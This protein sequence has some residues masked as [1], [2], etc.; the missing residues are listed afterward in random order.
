MDRHEPAVTE[1]RSTTPSTT[2]PRSRS[3]VAGNW[4]F[5][6]VLLLM[7]ISAPVAWISPRSLV[8]VE[9]PGLVD[10]SWHLD[11][12]FK[13]SRGIWIGRD[14]AFTHGPLFQWLSSLPARSTAIS[15]GGIYATWDTLPLWCAVL[16]GFL[17]LRLL[18]PQ[19]PA[20]KRFVLLLILCM[21]W[22]PSLRTMF[23]VFVFAALLR[24]WYAVAEE[25]VED[26]IFGCLA[27]VLSATAFLIAADQGMYALAALLIA[28]VTIALEMRA[29]KDVGQRFLKVW[30]A[31]ALCS[32]VLVLLV[33]F[34]CGRILD[35]HFWRDSFAQVATYRWATSYP[36]SSTG[37]L[38]LLGTLIGCAAILVIAFA[39]RK[40]QPTVVVQRTGYLLGAFLFGIVVMQSALVRA[41]YVHI[42][43]SCFVLIFLA[44][45]ALFAFESPA[46]SMVAVVAALLCSI[47]FADIAFRPSDITRSFAQLRNPLTA[48]PSELS[49]FDRGCFAPAFTGMLRASANYLQQHAA[50]SD[51]IVVFPYQTLF[52]IAA[53]RNVAGGLMQAYTASGAELSQ[54]EITGLQ[55]ASATAGLYLPDPD[56]KH[57]SGSA[58]DYWRSLGLSLPVDGVDNLTRTPEVWFWLLHHYRS[59][60]QLA[61]GVFGLQRDDSRISRIQ[62]QAQ[63]LG[64]GKQTCLVTDSN[65]SL[66]L[67]QVTWPD[68]A[69]LLRLHLTVRYSFLWKL[70]KPELM[71]LAISHAN[72]NEN[73]HWFVLAPN[74]ATDI[75]IYP[76]DQSELAR[77]FDADQSK[78]HSG[79]HSPVTHLRLLATPVDWLSQTPSAIEVESA[80]A[81]RVTMSPQ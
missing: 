23:A 59:D 63:P 11:S 62:L 53:R 29:V 64:V 56:Y 58:I 25:R 57:W 28:F 22:G 15:M 77:Y 43:L 1:I 66:D 44:G 51:S 78:W 19:Q 39:T 20:W 35:F 36:M 81:V 24:G 9:N 47:Y 75:W 54:V 7:V 5:L 2:D 31:F 27:A 8:V 18:L 14:V 45:T 74:V 16:F 50:A 41:D 26:W 21:F 46:I 65:S 55:E 30:L 67:G 40:S 38:R 49:E 3:P 37:A 73:V 12:V 52:G 72:G 76:W 32:V 48:C 34:F 79:P 10:D 6:V 4:D 71:Q 60:Q 17:A 80:E 70:R 68:G 42:V 69:D 13:A 33:N 61:P